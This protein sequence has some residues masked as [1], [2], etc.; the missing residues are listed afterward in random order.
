MHC[1]REDGSDWRSDYGIGWPGG[2]GDGERAAGN[3][4][5]AGGDGARCGER[6]LG[7]EAALVNLECE[8]AAGGAGL[9]RLR[10]RD[11]GRGGEGG[12]DAGIGVERER[13][14]GIGAGRAGTIPAGKRGDRAENSRQRDGRPGVEARAGGRLRDRAGADDAG[15]ER[16]NIY[17]RGGDGGVGV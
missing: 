9:R 10:R 5:T 17:I 12:G 1:R 7:A 4:A 13:A 2:G 15:G 14:N 8:G 16:V 6:G 11:C 3:G